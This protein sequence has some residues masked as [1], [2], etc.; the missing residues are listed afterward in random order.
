[1]TGACGFLWYLDVCCSSPFLNF[2]TCRVELNSA[3][4]QTGHDRCDYIV[5]VIEPSD[6]AQTM[7]DNRLTGRSSIMRA[8]TRDVMT[9]IV[10]VCVF[11]SA[12]AAEL[13]GAQ[14]KELITGKSVYLQTTGASVT[15]APGQGVIYYTADGNALYKTP[16]GVMWHGKWI[17]KDNTA[18]VDW[19]ESPNNACVK[20]D[21]QGDITNIVN[22]TT[23]ETRAKV[24]KIVAGNPENLAP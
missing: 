18:C 16:K 13:T 2:A 1:M 8:I 20:Y 24:V 11:G 19:K 9:S 23:G 4:C 15:G 5:S 3:Q 17:I 12:T 6:I 10:S 21:K 14:I 7:M 22:A